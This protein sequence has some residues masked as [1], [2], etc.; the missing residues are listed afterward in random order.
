MTAA[1]T[2]AAGTQTVYENGYESDSSESVCSV[3]MEDNSEQQSSG[4]HLTR[5]GWRR[6]QLF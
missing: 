2:A 1:Q 4:T 3:V 5:S 6:L